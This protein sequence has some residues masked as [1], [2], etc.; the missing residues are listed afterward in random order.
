MP[1]PIR[2]LPLAG[3]LFAFA[4]RAAAPAADT[5]PAYCIEPVEQNAG[6]AVPWWRERHEQKREQAGRSDV[7]LLM[8]GDSITQGW[9]G[10]GADAWQ[11]YYASRNAFNLG[12][13]GDRTEHVLWRLQHGAV[14]GMQPRLVVLLIGTNNTA[15][16]M[17]P[18]DCVTAGV[19]LIVGELRGRL[20]AVK[21]LLLG[22]FPHH[23]SPY[24][25]MRRRNEAI[26]KRIATLADNESV[27]F[28]DVG[29]VFLHEDGEL[30]R[31]LMPDFLHPN[32]AGYEAWAAAME[33]VLAKLFE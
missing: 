11:A 27:F 32:A 8:L 20:P 14:E 1:A 25:E 13:G 24:N 33:P 28:L 29:D 17:D 5:P 9:E 21:I 2:F 22:I 26:N 30:R 18:V 19:R 15:H 6:W 4:A 3:L 12:F 23:E 31:D 7:D 10:P 16:R